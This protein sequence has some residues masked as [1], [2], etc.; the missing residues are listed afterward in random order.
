MAILNRETLIYDDVN[1]SIELFTN[2]STSIT[3]TTYGAGSCE[4]EVTT[5][6]GES[7]HSRFMVNMGNAN[8]SST[9]SGEGQFYMTIADVDAI[10][11]SNVIGFTKVI[12]S[13][14]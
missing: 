10:R 1:G 14:G 2:N 12:A 7:W 8:V 13:M 6:N 3:L 5:D 9:L 4:F 11:V